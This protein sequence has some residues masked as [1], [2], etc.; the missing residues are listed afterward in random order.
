MTAWTG[1]IRRGDVFLVWL[2]PAVGSEQGGTRPVLILQNDIGNRSSPVTIVAAIT[3]K[4]FSKR[5][6]TNVSLPRALSGLHHDSTVML[7]QIRTL[8]RSRLTRWL[9]RVDETLMLEVDQAIR[10]SL[11]L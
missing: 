11:G 7:N 3:T 9:S 10:L 2:D 5:F 1:E 4:V 8:D 6:P